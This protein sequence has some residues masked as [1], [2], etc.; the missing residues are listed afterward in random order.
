MR[1]QLIAGG[2]LTLLLLT[3]GMAWAQT[4][5]TQPGQSK[6]ADIPDPATDDDPAVNADPA[7][8]EDSAD[9]E[10]PTADSTAAPLPWAELLDGNPQQPLRVGEYNRV[11]ETLWVQ[12]DEQHS[13][14]ASR[15]VAACAALGSDMGYLRGRVPRQIEDARRQMAPFQTKGLSAELTRY[16]APSGTN[17]SHRQANAIGIGDYTDDYT[18][19][20]TILELIRS[21]ADPHTYETYS[22]LFSYL[23]SLNLDDYLD[24]AQDDAPLSRSEFVGYVEQ[25]YQEWQDPTGNLGRHEQFLQEADLMI[26]DLLVTLRE[27]RRLLAALE[28]TKAHQGIPQVDT[29]KTAIA[30]ASST[31]SI[32]RITAPITWSTTPTINLDEDNPVTRRDFLLAMITLMSSIETSLMHYTPWCGDYRVESTVNPAQEMQ[33][34]VVNLLR[35]LDSLNLEI[36]ELINV[37]SR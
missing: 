22:Q 3:Q 28:A 31:Q 9:P 29:P 11:M 23:L 33:W 32:A 34:E 36:V 24:A 2:C 18:E 37:H 12:L 6:V 8:P 27:V 13:L 7:E 19:A 10:D 26:Q 20:E 4:T 16:S 14:R 15:I 21:G 35:D 25:F 30:P 5:P 17:P 1:W